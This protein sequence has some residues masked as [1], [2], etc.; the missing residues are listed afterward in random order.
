LNLESYLAL[1]NKADLSVGKENSE[2]FFEALRKLRT[3]DS[4]V[5]IAGNGGSAATASH[6]VVDFTKTAAATGKKGLRANALSENVALTTAFSNDVNFEASLGE[7]LRSLCSPSDALLVISVSGTSPNLIYALR[8]A[9]ELGLTTL[10]LLGAKGSGTANLYDECILVDSE[11]YQIVENSHM[12][13]I[14]WLVKKM[15]TEQ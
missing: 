5:W 13:F 9:R 10:G 11:D 2:R 4:R 7:T 6:A 12:T 1:Q 15:V 8:V 14:H 3:N